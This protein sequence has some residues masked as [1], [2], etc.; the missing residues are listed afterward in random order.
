MLLP[1]FCPNPKCQF[2]QYPE[3][4][5][6]PQFWTLRGTYSTNV[7]GTVQRFKCSHCGEGFSERTVHIDYYTKK[8]IDYKEINRATGAAESVISIAKNLGCRPETISNRQDRLARN[9]I[10][11]HARVLDTVILQEDVC[12]DGFE[13]FD[14]SQYYP[15]NIN[16]VAGVESQFLYAFTHCT[17]RRKGKMTTFQKEKRDQL[18]KEYRPP[19]KAL[20]K[21]FQQVVLSVIKLWYPEVKPVL[22]L[23]TDMHKSYPL[24]LYELTEL[25]EKLE[26]KTFQHEVF[27]SKIARNLF[28][29]LFP[30]NYWDRELRKDI[31]AYHR[32]STCFVRNVSN[33]LS[34]LVLYQ[35]WHNY[36]K[37]HRVN[38]SKKEFRTHAIMAGIDELVINREL[39]RVYTDRAF[40]SQQKL[41]DEQTKIWLKLH[42][43]P[44]KKRKNYVPSFA[45]AS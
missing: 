44:G 24:A 36:C 5:S 13:S 3:Q 35:N 43:T 34:R 6:H 37:L 21:A 15:N 16:L 27:S 42:V 40:L 19:K 22:T 2:H 31:A 8:T 14:K 20:I 1:P 30:V 26:N 33:G 45:K 25:K 17:I 18:E 23:K 4:G 7:S 11:M 32:E 41:T 38:R 12:A 28:N 10:A 39:N 29:K 9:H